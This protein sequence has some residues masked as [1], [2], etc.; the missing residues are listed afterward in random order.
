MLREA[1][2]PDPKERQRIRMLHMTA[3]QVSHSSTASIE[4][5][6]GAV[7]HVVGLQHNLTVPTRDRAGHVDLWFET[8]CDRLTSAWSHEFERVASETV[9][10][11]RATV[12][13]IT[14]FPVGGDRGYIVA[15]GVP[16]TADPEALEELVRALVRDANERARSAPP[17]RSTGRRGGRVRLLQAFGVVFGA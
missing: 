11:R 17:P 12:S 15:R 10:G 16:A 2:V 8:R 14:V 7:A 13:E 3:V 5:D 4:S 1:G 9:A 6:R